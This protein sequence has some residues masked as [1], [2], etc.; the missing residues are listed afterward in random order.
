M[1]TD[2]SVCWLRALAEVSCGMRGMQDKDWRLWDAATEAARRGSQSRLISQNTR[3]LYVK[4]TNPI[5]PSFPFDWPVGA[6]LRQVFG[7][8][9]WYV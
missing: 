3:D 7:N 6:D 5:S 2:G 1:E 9:T 4:A 8:V